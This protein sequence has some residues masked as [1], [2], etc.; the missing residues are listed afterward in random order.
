MLITFQFFVTCYGT[1]KFVARTFGS[2]EYKKEQ[3]VK[4]WKLIIQFFLILLNTYWMWNTY[5]LIQLDKEMHGTHWD[6]WTPLNLTMPAVNL[7]SGF[8][9]SEVKKAYRQLA[10]VYHPDKLGDI[11]G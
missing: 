5:Q 2:K 4:W 8:D 6:P 3:N 10:K 1:Y 7:M 9:T 11:S